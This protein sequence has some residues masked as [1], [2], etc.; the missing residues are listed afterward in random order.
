MMME[1]MVALKNLKMYRSLLAIC[2]QIFMMMMSTVIVTVLCYPTSNHP[3]LTFFLAANTQICSQRIHRSAPSPTYLRAPYISRYNTA[4]ALLGLG[5]LYT[6]YHVND[7]AALDPLPNYNYVCVCVCV[8]QFQFL[9]VLA[10]HAYAIV[11]S[12]KHTF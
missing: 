5:G 3:S 12:D 2:S 4:F 1:H 6:L 10:M 7:C 9:T 11:Y 8:N